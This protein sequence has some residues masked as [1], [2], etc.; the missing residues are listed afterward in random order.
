MTINETKFSWLRIGKVIGV[1]VIIAAVFGAGWAA[2]T[3][4]KGKIVWASWSRNAREH[5]LPCEDLPFYP[6]VQKTLAEHKDAVEKIRELGGN[7][8]RAEELRCKIW[9]GGY[10]YIKGDIAI[11]YQTRSQRKAIEKLLGD[12]FFGIP[13]E[14]METNN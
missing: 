13:W 11:D 5:F 10:G 6:Q 14:G 4:R 12:K 3:S 1:I 9:E 8:V 2:V 7:N